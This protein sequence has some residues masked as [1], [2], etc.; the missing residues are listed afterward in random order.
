LSETT[1]RIPEL[2]GLRGIAVLAVIASHY[3]IGRRATA[4]QVGWSGVSLFFVL[5]GF[6]IT[7]ICAAFAISR[8]TTADSGN[9]A[10]AESGRWRTPCCSRTTSR[11]GFSLHTF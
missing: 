5:S 10:P 3:A 8:G 4:L 9:A 2:D 6:L 1:A 11:R 7:T